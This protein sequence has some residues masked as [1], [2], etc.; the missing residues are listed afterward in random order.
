MNIAREMVRQAIKLKNLPDEE[1]PASRIS[2]AAKALIESQGEDG[3][4]VT[5]A[6]RQVDAEK[7]AAK[8]AMA[9]VNELLGV[10]A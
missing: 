3:K 2:Q 1:W 6:R 10:Q 5:T 4:I 9:S 8:E 7:E